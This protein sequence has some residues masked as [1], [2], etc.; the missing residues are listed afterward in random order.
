MTSSQVVKVTLLG[1]DVTDMCTAASMS[2][3]WVEIIDSYKQHYGVERMAPIAIFRFGF[4]KRR[5]YGEVRVT[6]R[7]IPVLYPISAEE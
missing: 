3:G 2:D 5:L 7:G 6:V 1:H 4:L